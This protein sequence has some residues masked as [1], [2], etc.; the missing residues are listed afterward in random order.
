MRPTPSLGGLRL[1]LD[2]ASGDL[3]RAGYANGFRL[4]EGASW[5]AYA[6]SAGYANDFASGTWAPYT[7]RLRERAKWALGISIGRPD[8]L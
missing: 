1:R 6:R 7:L 2:S 3:P 4:R 5:A 8:L